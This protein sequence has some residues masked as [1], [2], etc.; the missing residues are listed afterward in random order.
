MLPSESLDK[1]SSYFFIWQACRKTS[2]A[3]LQDNF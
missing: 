1:K 2:G 3:K